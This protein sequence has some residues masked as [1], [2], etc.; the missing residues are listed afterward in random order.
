M[1]P[2]KNAPATVC[3]PIKFILFVAG[4]EPNSVIAARNLERLCQEHLPGCHTIEVI[5][6]FQNMDIAFKNNIIITPTLIKVAPDPSVTIF[7]SLR[8]SQKLMHVLRP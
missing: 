2:S 5:D 8:D 3:E 4:Q 6:V 1:K 7:G